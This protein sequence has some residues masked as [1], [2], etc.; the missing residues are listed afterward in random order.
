VVYVRED[1]VPTNADAALTLN[2]YSHVL[3]PR[4]GAAGVVGGAAGVTAVCPGTR[5]SD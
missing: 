3:D 4:R 1:D 5:Q 2:L